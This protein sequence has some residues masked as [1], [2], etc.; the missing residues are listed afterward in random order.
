[1]SLEQTINQDIKAAMI[2]KDNVKLRGLR[3]IKSA[4]LLAKTEKTHVEDISEDAE[5]KVLQKLVKQ[6]KE[7]AEIYKTQNREDLY[8]VEIEEK[9]VIE[10]YLP[11]Q[12][13]Q[14]EIEAIVKEI[15]AETGASSI[16]DMG[17][18]MGLANQRLAGKADGSTI[19]QVV[20]AILA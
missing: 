1:M 8:Q 5:I 14:S 10:A 18:V 7:S 17:K 20:K 12:L 13:D 3:A 16:K 4:I 19:S 6:R 15:V 2:A 9:E 11:K